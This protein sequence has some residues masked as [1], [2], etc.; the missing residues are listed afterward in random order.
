[1]C[2]TPVQQRLAKR[3]LPLLWAAFLTLLV[4]G[5]WLASGYLFGTDWPGPRRFAYPAEV[6]SSAPLQV[7]LALVSMLI[8]SEATGKAL[9]FCLL[10]AAAWTSYRAVPTGSFVAR[11]SAST[12]FLVNPFV[13]G[14]LHYGQ[15]FLLAGYSVLPWVATELRELFQNPTRK[16][17]VLTAVSLWLL[18]TLSLHLTI[19]AAVL[20]GA[21]LITHIVA[22]QDTGAYIRRLV[23]VFLLTAS[24]TLVA[25]AYWVIPVLLGRGREGTTLAAIGP[26]D[27]T[28]Y[29]V[30]SD[31]S[32]GLLPNLLGLYGFWAE[33]TG[34]FA[35]MKEFVPD[36]PAALALL[37]GIATIG[38][39]STFWQ[40]QRRNLLAAWVAGLVLAAV[41]ALILEIGVSEPITSGLV[42]WLDANV[43][44]YLG[45][46]DAGKWA[47]LLA[48]VYS[49]LLGLGAVAILEAA[50]DRFERVTNARVEG[51][52]AAVLLALPLYYGN[53]LLFGSHGE[54]RPSQYPQGWYEADHVLLADD[55]SGRVLFLPWHGYMPLSFVGNQNYVIA[56]PAPIFFSRPV[57]VSADPEVRGI[58]PPASPDQTAIADLVRSGYPGHWAEVLASRN[59][60]YVLLAREYDW[61]R[62]QY[63]DSEPDLVKVQD[64]GSIVLYRNSLVP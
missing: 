12:V 8:S 11:A 30:V 7:A 31:P 29:A 53:G 4:A 36:W 54:V 52:A 38:A 14:R 39:V 51:I 19:V 13:Y 28:A 1:V 33:A 35:S 43:P 5:P 63:L 46:R 41:V 47:A 21:L 62:Y 20:A 56:S 18:G 6:S 40:P 9:V 58:A 17:A 2:P 3:A 50:K 16:T 55:Q 59:I 37:L 32:L 48:L 61:R 23:P 27:L 45:M 49:Q 60:K 25:S 42:G 57:L 15:L 24:L 10:F 22:R 64:F 34:R 26:G 44:I